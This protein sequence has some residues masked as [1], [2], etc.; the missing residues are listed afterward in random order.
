MLSV[1]IVGLGWFGK[2]LVAHL[3]GSDRIRVIRA[4]DIDLDG[5]RDFVTA[6]A[7]D[8]TDDYHSVLRDP[9]VDA[10]ILATPHGEHEAQVL[11]A[12]E[13]GK[14]IFCEKPLALSGAGAARM[15]DACDAAGIILG[16]GHERRYEAA[17]EEVKRLAD[18][19][20]FGTLLTL[21]CNWSHDADYF[22]AGGWRHDP[23]QAPLD[24]LTARGVHITDYFQSLAGPVAEV[25]TRTA[26]R[27]ASYP[28]DDVLSVQLYFENGVIGN[29]CSLATTPF[30]FRCSAFG[31]QG[32][33]DFTEP[34]NLDVDVPARLVTRNKAQVVN[35]QAL[36]RGPAVRANLHA[37]A[38]AVEGKAEYRFSRNEKLHNV[39]IM[40]AIVRSAETGQPVKVG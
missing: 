39:Q 11:A 16:I 1:A 14:Q 24:T 13:A 35:E 19:G 40:E 8:L 21:D 3:E 7:F 38:D 5:V 18:A 23:E 32:W 10:V 4:V 15:L 31:D 17:F 36:P 28:V 27:S 12:A 22:A 33:A 34:E 6:Q 30:Y 29:M 9:A 26:H 25:L 37:W 20:E 2:Q